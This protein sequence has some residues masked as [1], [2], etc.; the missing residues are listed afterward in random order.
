VRAGLR[1][2][3]F[4]LI[5]ELPHISTRK[6]V[7]EPDDEQTPSADAPQE[8]PAPPPA[9]APGADIAAR[10]IWT[11]RILSVVSLAAIM[12][13]IVLVGLS[14]FDN[15]KTG[16]AAASLYLLLPYTAIWAGSVIH[17]LPG[18]LVVWA[19]VFY[20][21]PLLS[22]AM[23]GAACG[24]MF[25]P[26]F[27]LP[28]WLTFYWRR[29]LRRFLAGLVVMYGLA[30]GGLALVAPDTPAFLAGLRQMFGFHLLIVEA[31]DLGGVWKYWAPVFRYPILAAF[32][33]LSLT[34]VLWP[35]QK[36]L[37]SLIA[38][39]AVLLLGTQFWHATSGG[40][41]LAWYLPLLL[42]V[43]FRPNLEDRTA[44]AVVR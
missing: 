18:A 41:A 21:R 6:A 36:N 27:L 31:G 7:G 5:F 33:G 19:I 23:I 30:I 1:G 25:Y 32:V 4:P 39:S 40:Y 12:I 29:G 44:L 24:A 22:G 34:M 37:G 38:C 17:A 15:I 42:L 35:A 8:A 14:H 3:G 26:L 2:P 13:G 43:I 16:L 9:S 28:L 11:A 20:R 10:R